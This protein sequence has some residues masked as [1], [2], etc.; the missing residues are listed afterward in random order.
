LIHNKLIE[1][2]GILTLTDICS[3]AGLGPGN[4]R[5][6]STEYYLS[7]PIVSDESKGVGAFM[8]AYVQLLL[9]LK[10]EGERS[11]EHIYE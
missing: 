7:E 3:V 11:E 1:K 4:T 8:M 2:N 9:L 6:G 5:D 10:E